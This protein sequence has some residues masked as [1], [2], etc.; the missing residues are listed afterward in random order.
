MGA[1]GRQEFMGRFSIRGPAVLTSKYVQ[2]VLNRCAM[3]KVLRAVESLRF[4][5]ND[6]QG[7]FE[8]FWSFGSRDREVP[9]LRDISSR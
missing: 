8:E 9:V 7:G 6:L 5:Y 3:C 1:G 2:A 4:G